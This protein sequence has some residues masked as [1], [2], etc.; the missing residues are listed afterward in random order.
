M[1]PGVSVDCG[2]PRYDAFEV[3]L[4]EMEQI[5][6]ILLDLYSRPRVQVRVRG[7][8]VAGVFSV[9]LA[10]LC[11]CVRVSACPHHRQQKRISNFLSL[12]VELCVRVFCLWQYISVARDAASASST[13]SSAIQSS[14]S[15]GAAAAVAT[16][17]VTDE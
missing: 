1:F 4:V 3:P 5:A 2:A 11:M 14:S 8:G 15:A 9:A 6:C 17:P 7:G 13:G 12:G 10:C 16:P